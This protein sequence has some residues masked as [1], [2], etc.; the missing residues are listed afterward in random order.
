MAHRKAAPASHN[1]HARPPTFASHAPRARGRALSPAVD[2]VCHL[3]HYA[4]A[5][6]AKPPTANAPPTGLP[7]RHP[8]L[9]VTCHQFAPRLPVHPFASRAP[10]PEAVPSPLRVHTSPCF[11]ALSTH[12]LRSA[13]SPPSAAF[14][15]GGRCWPLGSP[16]SVERLLPSPFYS[17]GRPK[18]PTISRPPRPAASVRQIRRVQLSHPARLHKQ[19]SPW[20]HRHAPPVGAFLPPASFV[21]ASLRSAA[22]NNTQRSPCSSAEGSASL[23]ASVPLCDAHGWGD[24]ACGALGASPCNVALPGSRRDP[25]LQMDGRGWHTPS[26]HH[27]PRFARLL[28]AKWTLQTSDSLRSSVFAHFF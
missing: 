18:P 25:F 8:R 6:A 14:P 15:L 7:S 5:E 20:A 4:A 16:V 3:R 2:F 10:T 9:A 27:P 26:R 12:T 24:C 17:D 28:V 23:H 13:S 11:A 22:W 21:V 1:P 19:G